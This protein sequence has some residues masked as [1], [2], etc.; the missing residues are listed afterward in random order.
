MHRRSWINIATG[1][2]A[3]RQAHA[4]AADAAAVDAPRNLTDSLILR[5]AKVSRPGGQWEDEDYDVF[6]GDRD[7]GRIYRVTDQPDSAWFWGV[8]F[9]LTGRKSYGHAGVRFAAGVSLESELLHLRL[10]RVRRAFIV[11]SG[12][13]RYRSTATFV[14]FTGPFSWMV[15]PFPCLLWN[16][17][18]IL[19]F[20]TKRQR[21]FVRS[22]CKRIRRQLR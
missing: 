7:V 16:G 21:A 6:D 8:S 18:P 19:C 5:R 15:L 10:V 12:P 17:L 11:G 20:S 2:R 14:P 3:C 1:G 13:Y 22:E 4:G 9:D